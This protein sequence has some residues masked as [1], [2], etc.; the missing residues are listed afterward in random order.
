[1]QKLDDKIIRIKN[2]KGRKGMGW[3]QMRWDVKGQEG[4]RWNEIKGDRKNRK[5]RKRG[6]EREG[7]GK[8]VK[9]R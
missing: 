6:E 7:E 5:G 2:E 8:G 4:T 9:T 3:D 1:M